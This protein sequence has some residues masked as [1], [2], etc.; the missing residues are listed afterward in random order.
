MPSGPMPMS[1]QQ[2]V[3]SSQNLYN[4]QPDQRRYT[5][6]AYQPGQMN[7]QNNDYYQGHPQQQP[8]YAP[9]TQ[10]PFSLILSPMAQIEEGEFEPPIVDMGELGPVRCNRCKAYMSPFMQ[11]IDAGRRFQCL[12]CRATTEETLSMNDQK[13][14][15][16]GTICDNTSLLVGE[17]STYARNKLAQLQEK[18]TNKMQALSALKTALKP[19]NKVL[20]ILAKEVEWLLGEKRQL[21]A[22]LN[23]TEMWAEHLG[24]WRADV[25]SAETAQRGS[26]KVFDAFQNVQL[27]KQLFY[28][29]GL[30]FGVETIVGS[31]F[32]RLTRVMAG[33]E[34]SNGETDGALLL[35]GVALQG[36]MSDTTS[37]LRA[38]PLSS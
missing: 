6:N 32:C 8:Q 14:L 19:E 30:G 31:S 15:M 28:T 3:H 35:L 4:S 18:L 1:G 7:Y 17:H 21:E 10:I 5:Q 34:D 23:H 29:M 9:N 12:L 16:N 13:S 11:F 22:H 27:N 37:G 38:G 2:P 25:Q 33:G 24:H 36:G 26:T 20:G